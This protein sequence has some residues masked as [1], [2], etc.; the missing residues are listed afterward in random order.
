MNAVVAEESQAPALDFVWMELTNRCNLHC[1]HCYAESSPY[2]GARDV[3]TEADYLRLIREVRSL[4]C[5]NIQFIGG[6]PT[7]NRSL[8]RLIQEAAAQGFPFIEVFTNLIQLPEAL[9]QT[10]V[11]FN[12]A[13]ATSFYSHDPRIHDAITTHLGSFDRTVI[14]M[15]RVLA[16]GLRLR[17]GII[18]M[19]QNHAG[20]AETW[21][22]LEAL[23][24]ANIGTDRVRGI[25]R[26]DASQAC[27]M[28]ELCG[29]CAGPILSIGPD[30]VIAPCNLSKYW[31]VGSV[32]SR[33]LTDIV[34][35]PELAVIRRQ[36][37]ESVKHRTPLGPHA[38]CT[39]KTCAPY[40]SCCPSTQSCTPCAPHGCNPCYP[41]G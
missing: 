38:I 23:G 12:V 1:V 25:G 21:E 4:G 6:E 27:A 41:K 13:V 32:L 36:I 26:A 40:S 34:G 29:S 18:V 11:E 31:A 37:S 20:V 3:L 14:N 19:E 17:A 30:G 39:P 5:P 9:L 15:Q 16:A 8:P 2:S 10:F 24:V 33:T 28:G 35:S 7:L 22:F